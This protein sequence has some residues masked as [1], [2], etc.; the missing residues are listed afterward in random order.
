MLSESR[1]RAIVA[2]VQDDRDPVVHRRTEGVVLEWQ[3]WYLRVL[4]LWVWASRF[5]DLLYRLWIVRLE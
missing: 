2:V 3:Q 4:V 1:R 5:V